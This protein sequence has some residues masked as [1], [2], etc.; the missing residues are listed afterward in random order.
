MV[1]EAKLLGCKLH[2]NEN[3]QHKDEEWFSTD[4]IDTIDQ[5][6]RN[7]H[8]VFW[9][10]IQ[11]NINERKTL[12]GYTTTKNC[13]EQKY[14]F[15]ES[16]VSMLSFCDEVC[17]VDGGSSD[18][19]WELLQELANE[20]DKLKIMQVK[21]DWEHKRFAVFD[22]LQ[23]AAARKMCTKDFCWQMDSD[24]I[25]HEDD[26]T[27]IH[28]II[29]KFPTDCDLLALPVIE[30]WGSTEKVRCDINSWKWRLSRNASHITHGIPASLRKYDEDGNMFSALGSD[31]C[32]YIHE[33]T[34]EQI[35][36]MNFCAV[37]YTHLTLP[38]IYS[39]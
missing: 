27:K 9:A 24:E 32:D 7:A 15:K 19:T 13:I 3:V 31:G 30:Y 10:K 20:N 2:L 25:V 22:G 38:T 36:F 18:G 14:P 21:R 4:D 39:V 11:N 16:I 23:K 8:N 12:S 26:G 34:G 37:S 33:V 17:V 6:L 1:I 5:Y 29:N 35:N 28:N